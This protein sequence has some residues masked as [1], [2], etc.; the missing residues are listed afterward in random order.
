MISTTPC[1]LCTAP[2]PDCACLRPYSDGD[3]C[4]GPTVVVFDH[5]VEIAARAGDLRAGRLYAI[6]LSMP[7]IREIRREPRSRDWEKRKYR[8]NHPR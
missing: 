2:S 8:K 5:V 1:S 7:S 4:T 6:D 3:Q